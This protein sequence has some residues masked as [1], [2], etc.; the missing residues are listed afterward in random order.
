MNSKITLIAFLLG[1]TLFSCKKENEFKDFKYADKPMAFTCEGT[2]SKLLNEALYSFEDDITNH[3]SRSPQMA[4]LSKAYSQILRVSIYGNLKPED[5]VSE[6]TVK[7][8][9]A[10]KKEDNLWSNNTLNYNSPAL[11]CISS[12]IIDTN[13]KTTLNA[14]L[15]TNSMAPKLFGAAIVTNYKNAL[16]DKNLAMYIALDLYYSKMFGVD[17]SKIN[18]DKPEQK[19]DFNQLPSIDK[20]PELD[21]HAGHDH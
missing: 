8:F 9:E 4:S 5:M 21:P 17:F 20:K 1:I 11:K 2:N 7:V 6:H 18:F 15:S 3:Y 14:L 13:I 12:G 19:V 10:L 16:A